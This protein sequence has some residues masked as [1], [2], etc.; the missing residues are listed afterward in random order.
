VE[1][2]GDKEAVPLLIR[3]LF[4][5]IG[6][7]EYAPAPR[8]ILCG[9]LP[10]LLR[11]G[12]LEKFV[13]YAG[14][15]PDGDSVLLVVDCD[16]DC[17]PNIVGTL[18]QRV[19]P[20]AHQH[21]KRVGIALMHREFETLFLHAVPDLA[22]RFSELPWKIESWDANRDWTEIRGAKAELRR[23]MGG[24]LYRETG[25]QARFVSALDL[26][27]LEERCRSLA[28]LINTLRW[29]TNEKKAVVVYPAR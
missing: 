28:H 5:E 25:H 7:P 3:R 20:L 27:T 2:H 4:S 29:L 18:A 17:P 16:D 21:G 15:R 8:P 12:V 22:E 6:R 19:E 24:R 1:G 10:K 23:F 11:D 26:P 14:R 9:D 13:T